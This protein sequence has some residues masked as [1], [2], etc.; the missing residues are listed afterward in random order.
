MSSI[1]ELSG[2]TRAAMGSVIFSM[3]KS[4]QVVNE[5]MRK[6][7]RALSGINILEVI[8]E[9]MLE[10][11]LYRCF[12]KPSTVRKEFKAMIWASLVSLFAHSPVAIAN[13]GQ[14]KEFE[15]YLNS[16]LD[17]SSYTAVDPYFLDFVRYMRIAQLAMPAHNNQGNL[18]LICAYLESN[19]QQ[20]VLDYSTGSGKTDAVKRRLVAYHWFA[21][22]A[23]AEGVDP[24]HIEK[25]NRYV[26]EL[27]KS[28]AKGDTRRRTGNQPLF[29]TLEEGEMDKLLRIPT[30][31]YDEALNASRYTVDFNTLFPEVRE[32]LHDLQV[33]FSDI[34]YFNVILAPPLVHLIYQLFEWFGTQRTKESIPNEMKILEFFIPITG[35]GEEKMIIVIAMM[36]CKVLVLQKA[37][38]AFGSWVGFPELHTFG[39]E[40]ADIAT[41]AA[42]QYEVLH[43]KLFIQAVTLANELCS[44][45]RLRNKQIVLFE[46]G[47]RLEGSGR[48]Y[49]KGGGESAATKRRLKIISTITGRVRG[50]RGIVVPFL[51][52][53]IIQPESAWRA[54]SHVPTAV[55]NSA[56]DVADDEA[57][58]VQALL[59]IHSSP[60][61]TLDDVMQTLL[62][63]NLS[64]WMID[65][66]TQQASLASQ[67]VLYSNMSFSMSSNA[68]RDFKAADSADLYITPDSQG[69]KSDQWQIASMIKQ[70]H[71]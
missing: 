65:I 36:A 19:C 13:A 7:D 6:I 26:L 33:V 24:Q 51:L 28:H 21:A 44:S 17:P 52:A 46:I 42:R 45:E 32:V 71:K 68:V 31:F 14:V 22:N 57:D 70:E 56:M 27:A 66:Q 61:Q 8:N 67:G 10:S 20:P 64:D 50:P 11:V 38:A 3:C 5:M 39:L 43:L 47:Q 69:V 60:P 62:D 23:H 63:S 34:P 40:Y 25:A 15:N 35:K 53:T 37:S 41:E 2:L 30:D 48:V 1:T 49:S 9:R 4:E 58:A 18:L 29:I 55:D 16:S 59:S 12:E 54:S